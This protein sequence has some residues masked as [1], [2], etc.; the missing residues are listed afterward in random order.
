MSL[1]WESWIS[2]TGQL[3]WFFYLLLLLVS[4]QLPSPSSE[5]MGTP[6]PYEKKDSYPGTHSLSNLLVNRQSSLVTP[7]YPKKSSIFQVH[8][9]DDALAPADLGR[10]HHPLQVASDALTMVQAD[11]ISPHRAS[12]ATLAPRPG[13][14]S[15][16]W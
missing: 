3:S 8:P 9:L 4:F 5:R 2:L 10:N 1:S 6:R 13:E 14:S 11:L 15:M 16:C 7:E 12:T